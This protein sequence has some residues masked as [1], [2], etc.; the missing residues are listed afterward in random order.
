MFSRNEKAKIR[1]FRYENYAPSAHCKP[2]KIQ[3]L[4][5]WAIRLSSSLLSTAGTLVVLLCYVFCLHNTVYMFCYFFLA[6][7]QQ[8]F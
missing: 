5:I 1:I 8:I 4:Q 6:N 2:C 7:L 3:Y